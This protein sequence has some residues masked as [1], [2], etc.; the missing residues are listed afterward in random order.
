MYKRWVCLTIRAVMIVMI[1]RVESK[2]QNK[3]EWLE[4]VVLA[5]VWAKVS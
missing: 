3:L 4:L 5:G 2:R 1:S